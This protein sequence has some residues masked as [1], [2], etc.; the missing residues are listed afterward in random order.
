MAGE[1]CQQ[2]VSNKPWRCSRSAVSNG[3]LS[4]D[5]YSLLQERISRAEGLITRSESFQKQALNTVKGYEKLLRKLRSEL[6][7]LKGLKLNSAPLTSLQNH[8]KSSNL[9]YLEAVLNNVECQNNIV[10]IFKKF[11]YINSDDEDAEVVMDIEA[12]NGRLWVKVVAR[13]PLALHRVWSGQGQ[14][15]EKNSCTLA[16]ECIEAA[17]QNLCNYEQP[18]IAFSFANG[19]TFS[20]AKEMRE[21]SIIVWGEIVPDPGITLDRSSDQPGEK[22]QV[23]SSSNMLENPPIKENSCQRINLDITTL[24]ALVSSM[25]NGGSNFIFQEDVLTQ[26]AEE[27]RQ[28]PTL[29]SLRAFLDQKDLFVCETALSDFQSILKTVGGPNE[30]RRANELLKGVQVIDDSPSEN[31]LSLMES[32]RIKSRSKIIFGTGETLK[33]ITTTANSSFVRAATN[34]GVKFCVFIHPSR[35]L[36]EQKEAKAT[37]LP[38]S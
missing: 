18:M 37:K 27:E 13:N 4:K 33:A 22:E 9:T 34:Q 3:E 20:M 32:T 11:C 35:A 29:P 23:T 16:L 19:V 28:E 1:P 24:V 26:Q 31:S 7:F 17:K 2:N 36:S 38:C 8:L 25:T 21:N 5:T 30:L 6:N 15:G 14:Y 12:E 10:G